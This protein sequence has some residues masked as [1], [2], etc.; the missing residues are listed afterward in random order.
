MGSQKVL[1]GL[2]LGLAQLGEACG[3]VPHGAVMLA[4][5]RSSL[6]LDRGRRIAVLHETV[7]QE[8]ETRLG[9]VHVREGCAMALNEHLRALA[10]KR[11]DGLLAECALDVIQRR[12]SEI[13]VVDVEGMTARVGQREHPR[14]SATATHGRRPERSLIIRLDEPLRYESVKVAAYDRRGVT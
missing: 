5:L 9:V 4:Q 13:V 12:D 1:E 2:G 8:H 7:G 6:G 11:E 3:G 14:R 10:S